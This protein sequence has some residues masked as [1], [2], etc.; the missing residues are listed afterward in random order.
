MTVPI[1]TSMVALTWVE[2]PSDQTAL[3]EYLVTLSLGQKTITDYMRIWGRADDWCEERGYSLA[4]APPSVI[5]EYVRMTP[6]THAGRTQLR[7][8]LTRYWE[9]IDRRDAPRGAVRVPPQPRGVCKALSDGEARVLARLAFTYPER[10]G[11]AVLAGLYLGLRAA[12]IAA[13]H[14]QRF[15]GAM[16]WYLC[17][18]KGDRVRKLPV[19]APLRQR[20]ET[21]EDRVGWVFPGNVRRDGNHV[22]PTTVWTWC[23]RLAEE[24]GLLTIHTHQ[25][26]HTAIATMND[27]TKDLRTAQEFAGHAKPETTAVYTRTTTQRLQAAVATLDY[28]DPDPPDDDLFDD[29]A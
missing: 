10:E 25:L 12:E 21:H 7:T 27:R 28:L 4:T 26:R 9:M 2:A 3:R 20:L 5:A 1:P 23:R 6:A 29:A 18:G 14:W 15:D 19:A 16:E 22:H 11:T 8:V 17:H 24:A 13:M